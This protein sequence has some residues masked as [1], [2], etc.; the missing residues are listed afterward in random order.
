MRHG[1]KG[2][3]SPLLGSAV[4]MDLHSFAASA[5][6]NAPSQHVR[7]VMKAESMCEYIYLFTHSSS[8][9]KRMLVTDLLLRSPLPASYWLLETF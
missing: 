4:W 2:P 7:A 5:S 3:I 8:S 1:K 9:I 6:I